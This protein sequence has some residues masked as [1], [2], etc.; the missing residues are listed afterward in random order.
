MS[1]DILDDQFLK[2]SEIDFSEIKF[3]GKLAGKAWKLEQAIKKINQ[4]RIVLFVLGG[5]ITALML[6]LTFKTGFLLDY[7]LS[8]IIGL[9]FI[10]CGFM[11]KKYPIPSIAIPLALYISVQLI[12]FMLNNSNLY[13]GSA[14]K[15]AIVFFLGYGIYNAVVASKIKK[16]LIEAAKNMDLKNKTALNNGYTQAG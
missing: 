3:S 5:L 1:K 2:N 14:W 6:F 4:A 8:L 7:V 10:G 12:D 16:E 11:V 13:R 15:V 9:I